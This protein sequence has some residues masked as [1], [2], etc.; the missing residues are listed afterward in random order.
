ML[1]PTIMQKNWILGFR[2]EKK[3]LNSIYAERIRRIWNS[4]LAD[5][6]V[7]RTTWVESSILIKTWVCRGFIFK[8]YFKSSSSCVDLSLINKFCGITRKGTKKKRDTK[9]QIK[10]KGS[11]R[12][13]KLS[14]FSQTQDS[15]Y[16]LDSLSWMMLGFGRNAYTPLYYCDRVFY[17]SSVRISYP[18]AAVLWVTL[19][20]GAT[21]FILDVF[22]VYCFPKFSTFG[23]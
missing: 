14:F 9:T 16:V 23:C 5:S 7:A 18:R 13:L 22:V 21:S 2:L 4:W 20:E 17:K 8:K 12:H 15:P 3:K 11:E 10:R 1:F 19:C 6:F